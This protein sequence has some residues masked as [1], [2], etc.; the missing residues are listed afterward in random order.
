MRKSLLLLAMTIAAVLAGVAAP[1]SAGTTA[2]Y[3]DNLLVSSLPSTEDGGLTALL[4]LPPRTMRAGERILLTSRLAGQSHAVRMPRMALRV[5]AVGAGQVLRS[6]VKAINHDGKAYGTQYV[7]VRWLFIAPVAGTYTITMRAEA[8]TYLG[9]TTLTVVPGLTYLKVSRVGQTSVQWGD[10]QRG[11]V[12]A[13]AHPD[14]DNPA[15]RTARSWAD[16]LTQ[17]VHK[18]SATR[19]TLIGDVELSREYGS[20]PGGNSRVSVTLA[21]TPTAANGTPCAPRVTVT[22]PDVT[23]TSNK[24]HWHQ[25]MTLPDVNV[26]CGPLLWVK[27]TVDHLSGNPVGI[28]NSTQSNGIALLS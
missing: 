2:D 11:C 23:I 13:V 3:T 7:S 26:S 10:D 17:T 9:P 25:T 21:A 22:D 28:E 6:P 5:D 12:G 19:A 1:A 24:H 18:G 27:V 14:P 4:Q 15:C 16:T 8:T 20:Y